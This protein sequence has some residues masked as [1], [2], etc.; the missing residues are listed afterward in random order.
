MLEYLFMDLSL[1]EYKETY[2]FQLLFSYFI[3]PTE[4]SVDFMT[5]CMQF[6][7]IVVHSTESMNYRSYL[8]YELTLLGLDD[9]LEVFFIYDYWQESF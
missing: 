8:Q 3:K 4:F 9:Y 1:Q 7:N 6:F 2:R 5:S